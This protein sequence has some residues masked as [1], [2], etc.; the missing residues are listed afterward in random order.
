MAV[1]Q[2]RDPKCTFLLKNKHEEQLWSW[3]FIVFHPWPHT[4]H[5]LSIS[6][7]KKTLKNSS[8]WREYKN[9]WS[10]TPGVLEVCNL[11]LPER[12]STSTA[13]NVEAVVSSHF[14]CGDFHSFGFSL[15]FSDYIDPKTFLR[16]LKQG[17]CFRASGSTEIQVCLSERQAL[18]LTKI[19]PK[20]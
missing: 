13:M 19:T 1:G 17:S 2:K 12:T 14:S 11:G 4:S 15:F 5:S 9:D 18:G 16:F 3:V 20:K 7:I 8:R 6:I 10:Q